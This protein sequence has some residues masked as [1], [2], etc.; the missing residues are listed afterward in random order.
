MKEN[1]TRVRDCAVDLFLCFDWAHG[2][3]TFVVNGDINGSGVGPLECLQ[4]EGTR[5]AKVARKR[6]RKRAR[7]GIIG[8]FGKTLDTR[9]PRLD[10]LLQT[11]VL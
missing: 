7:K 4:Q 11:P 10:T 5:V 2:Y 6:A 3:I 9:V 1:Y 8:F